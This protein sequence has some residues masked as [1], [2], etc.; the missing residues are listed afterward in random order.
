MQQ[1]RP[2]MASLP[3]ESFLWL[4]SRARLLRP[5]HIAACESCMS[6]FIRCFARG[7]HYGRMRC[8][9]VHGQDTGSSI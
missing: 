8:C 3:T 9:T 6:I 5:L 2:C 4:S 1:E 7:T